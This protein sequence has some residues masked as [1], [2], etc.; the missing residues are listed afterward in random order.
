MKQRFYDKNPTTSQAV[1]LLFK[2]PVNFQLLIGK[3][4]SMIAE[5]EFKARELLQSYKSLG[6][7]KVL[8]MYKAKKKLRTY[9]DEPILH[10]TMMY[11][12]LLTEENQV[13]ISKKIIKLVGHMEKYLVM[14]SSYKRGPETKHAE[15]IRDT[16]VLHGDESVEELLTRMEAKFISELKEVSTSGSVAR[17]MDDGSSKKNKMK[18]G[19]ADQTG[20]SVGGGDPNTMENIRDSDGNMKI[21]ED[22]L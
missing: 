20:T 22:R 10:E 3:G 8:A 17:E 11:L 5:R 2:F 7:E 6:A 16:Y 14:C 1:G 12:F 9:D 21:K 4:I 15:T 18:P 13:L 19:S